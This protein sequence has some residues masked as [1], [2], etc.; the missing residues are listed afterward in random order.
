MPIRIAIVGAGPAGFYA[1]DRLLRAE[2]ADVRVELL[3]RLPTPWGLVRAGVAPDHPKIKNV[4][5]VYEKTAAL[6]GFHFHGNI[7]V[8][9]QISH[10]DL[11]EHHHAVIYAYGASSDRRLGIPGEELPGVVGA[12]EFVAWYNGHPDHSA[13]EFDLRGK[14]AVVVGNGNVALDVARMLVLPREELQVTDTADYAIE[15]IASSTI[16]EVVVLGRRGPAQAAYT[17]PEL[18][19]LGEL[20]AADIVVDP[21]EVELDEGSARW[22]ERAPGTN[23]K[24]VEVVREFAQRAPSGKPKRVVLRYLCSPV[25]IRGDERGVRELVVAH[26]ELQTAEDGSQKA[27]PTGETETIQCDLVLRSIGYRGN[28][29]E[30]VAFSER[31]ATIANVEGRVV[32]EHGTPVTGVYATGWIKRGPTGVIGTNKKCAYE[33]VDHLLADLAQDKLLAPEKDHLDFERLLTERGAVRVDYAGWEKIDEYERRLG[34]EQGRPRVKLTS[35]AEL[36]TH[37][38]GDARPE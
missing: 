34:E 38:H 5:R 26:N 15:A 28:P 31:G 18:R 16:E 17:T 7:D 37:A 2:G 25:E 14:R 10:A 24:N 8:G 13:R 21:A 23:R 6:D 36:L 29:I 32:D 11:L 12:T 3:D 30:G 22:L 4:S 19:E 27:V 33:T 35:T 1:A 9:E 20:T